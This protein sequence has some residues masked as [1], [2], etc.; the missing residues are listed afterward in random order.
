ML[1]GSFAFSKATTNAEGG[2][3]YGL[4]ALSVGFMQRTWYR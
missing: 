2:R 3:R 4:V 1:G